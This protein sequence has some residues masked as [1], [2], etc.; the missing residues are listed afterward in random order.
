MLILCC[1]FRPHERGPD[2]LPIL[3]DVLNST[4]STARGELACSLALNGIRILCEKEVVN[5]RSVWS[6]LEP[7]LARETRY[8]IRVRIKARFDADTVQLTS[9]V[10]YTA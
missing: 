2:V 1:R 4:C 10:Y 3:S 6:M 5:L 7:L 8:A 9:L